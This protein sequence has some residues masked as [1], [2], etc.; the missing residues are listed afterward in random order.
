VAAQPASPHARAARPFQRGRKPGASC[1]LPRETVAAASVQAHDCAVSSAT[2]RARRP[3]VG[4]ARRGPQTPDAAPKRAARRARRRARRSTKASHRGSEQ[5]SGSSVRAM[6][7]HA[8]G[9]RA[10]PALWD[11]CIARAC[12]ALRLNSA[13]ESKRDAEG[14]AGLRPLRVTIKKNDRSRVG[15]ATPGHG[16]WCASRSRAFRFTRRV[17]R[18]RL[19]EQWQ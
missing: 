12:A 14:W 3:S 9:A 16:S 17:L 1:L 10:T 5:R 7:E 2:V 18:A 8:R 11:S 4:C 6:R 15:L 13:A 19:F